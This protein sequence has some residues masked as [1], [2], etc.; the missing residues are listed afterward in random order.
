MT[1]QSLKIGNWARWGSE[2]QM[3]NLNLITPESVIRASRLVKKGRVYSLALPI[4][5]TGVPSDLSR[6]PAL[7]LMKLDGGDYLAGAKPPGGVS[8]ADDY[9]IMACHGTTHID[10]LAH[11]WIE[12]L[13]YNGFSGSLVRSSGAHKL[14]IENVRQLVTR[15]VLLDI[16][17]F[18]GIPHL[19]G[20]YAITDSDL[21]ACA[22][23]Q[24]VAAGTGDVLL[25]RTGW[26]SVFYQ[27]PDEF[28]RAQPG[29]GTSSGKWI[30]EREIVA[31]GADNI[32]VEVEPAEDGRSVVPLHVELL[33]NHGIYFMELLDLEELARDKVF[34]FLFV[35]APL[36]IFGGVG[37]PINPLAIC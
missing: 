23:A 8:A 34:E 5:R 21:Q 36:R 30:I 33:R 11:V 27:N 15:G 31:V 14:G 3:G 13:M 20:G 35:A 16:A 37:S 18:K 6:N 9:L 24:G 22:A 26:L 19:E 29:L 2:D 32:A 7:H 12:N 1:D 25:I 10:A 28:Y 17:R 4:R